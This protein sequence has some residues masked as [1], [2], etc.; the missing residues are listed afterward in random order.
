MAEE[1]IDERR[2]LSSNAQPQPASPDEVRNLPC[3]AELVAARV[4]SEPACAAAACAA[5]EAVAVAKVVHRLRRLVAEAEATAERVATEERLAIKLQAI[6]RGRQGRAKAAAAAAAEVSSESKSELADALAGFWAAA[7]AV[8]AAAAAAS[9]R[10]SF[11]S[12]ADSLEE[13]SRVEDSAAASHSD[14]EFEDLEEG[15]VG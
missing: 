13:G 8:E 6:A 1:G 12:A 11:G 9:R 10:S 15:G 2:T 3:T 14:L 4:A 7:E 5:P